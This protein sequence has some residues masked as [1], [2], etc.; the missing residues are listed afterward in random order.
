MAE[1]GTVELRPQLLVANGLQ[2]FLVDPRGDEHDP[3]HP[4][5]DSEAAVEAA[6]APLPNYLEGLELVHRAAHAMQTMEDHSLQIQTKAFEVM[7]KARANRLESAERIATLEKQ[8]AAVEM[9][10]EVLA[11]QLADAE[12]RAGTA[13]EWLNRFVE[14]INT[15]FAGKRSCQPDKIRSAA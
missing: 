5:N 2:E 1:R 6:L 8:L 3:G 7:Q 4:L 10:A 15:G 13:E 14:A 9:R 11:S 12:Q